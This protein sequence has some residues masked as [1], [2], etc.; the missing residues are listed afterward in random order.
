MYNE[1]EKLEKHLAH[2][3]YLTKDEVLWF[4][5]KYPEFKYLGEAYRI[6]FFSQKTKECDISNDASFSYDVKGIKYYYYKQDL[7]YYKFVQLYK[8]SM[9][10]LDFY[11]IAQY[12]QLKNIDMIYK[13]KEVILGEIYEKTLLFNGPAEK[14]ESIL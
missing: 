11:K 6:L 3:D 4:I 12:F 5:T 8:V 7:D 10:G 9:I 1:K 14:I 13:E 2:D